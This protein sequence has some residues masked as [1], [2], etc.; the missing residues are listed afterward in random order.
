MPV[1]TEMTRAVANSR[2]PSASERVT[3]NSPALRFLT[4]GPKRWRSRSYDV[5]RSPAK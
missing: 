1:T 4:A 3:M 2:M 5:S